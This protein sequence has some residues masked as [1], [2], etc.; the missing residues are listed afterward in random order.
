MI[1]PQDFMVKAIQAWEGVYSGDPQD[2]GNWANGQLIGSQYGVT[3]AV[4]AQHRGI[5]V[6]EITVDVMKGV[7]IEE[8]AAIGLELF[9]KAPH[10]DLLSWCAATAS[11]LDFGWGAGAGQAVKSMQRIVGV[12]ADGVLGPITA[13]AY[14]DW[15]LKIGED[16][17]AQAIH[18]MRCD[19]YR[20]IAR[21]NPVLQ[22]YLKG[23]FNRSDWAL[24]EA[25]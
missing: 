25:A 14:N 18:D 15:L 2:P 13:R 10:F 22:K 21:V 12:T 3:P 11:L 19:F 6:S 20:E 1:S 24:K 4:L 9:Y 5:P 8:A 16:Q 17:A 7:Q 23:W